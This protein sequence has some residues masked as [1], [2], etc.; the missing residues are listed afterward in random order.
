MRDRHEESKIEQILGEVEAHRDC[1]RC[2]KCSFV[3]VQVFDLTG[4]Q[5]QGT[6]IYR[7]LNRNCPVDTFDPTLPEVMP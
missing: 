6:G 4:P 7:C 3:C 5:V 2:P 1:R